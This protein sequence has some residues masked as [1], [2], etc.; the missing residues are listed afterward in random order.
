MLQCCGLF[1]PESVR[2]ML[3][4]LMDRKLAATFSY[5]GL[6]EKRLKTKHCFKD[7]PIFG[8]MLGE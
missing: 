4:R 1:L 6:G 3:R 7:L 8:I 2:G 5:S